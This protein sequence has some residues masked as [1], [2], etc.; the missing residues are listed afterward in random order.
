M[1]SSGLAAIGARN[2]YPISSWGYAI[3]ERTREMK[4]ALEAY[5]SKRLRRGAWIDFAWA[6]AAAVGGA[7]ILTIAYFVTYGVIWFFLYIL[8]WRVPNASLWAS[9]GSGL[10]M[11]LAF[12]ESRRINRKLFQGYTNDSSAGE[13]AFS[14][15]LSLLGVGRGPGGLIPLSPAASRNFASVVADLLYSGPRLVTNTVRLVRRGRAK[16]AADSRECA[17]VLMMALS[18]PGRLP[19]EQIR[20]QN[21]D[22]DLLALS[23]QLSW[24]KGVAFFVT[25]P[26]SLILTAS[27]RVELEAVVTRHP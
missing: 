16:T 11:L 15:S 24:L 7:V 10:V 21:P 12:I 17:E 4:D 23:E 27:F 6:V 2:D 25:E 1:L 19:F 26:I 8:P 22:C 18:E 13:I 14:T 20:Q 5:V 3:Q 9:A